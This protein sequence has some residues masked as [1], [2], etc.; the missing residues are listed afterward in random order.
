[1]WYFYRIVYNVNLIPYTLVVYLDSCGA[2]IYS[3][4]W[5]KAV[6]LNYNIRIDNT[7]IHDTELEDVKLEVNYC[8]FCCHYDH[9]RVWK[10]LIINGWN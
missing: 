1:L 2:N 3:S 8:L 10:G 5:C 4:Q 6:Y 7:M 9:E